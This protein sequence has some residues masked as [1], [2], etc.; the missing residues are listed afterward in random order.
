VTGTAEPSIVI[1]L[2]TGSDKVRVSLTVNAPGG[3]TTIMY[4]PVS[5]RGSVSMSLP[6]VL[7]RFEAAVIQE[8]NPGFEA[9]VV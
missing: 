8:K 3:L 9:L 7:M 5:G 6:P 2:V 1:V 4:V